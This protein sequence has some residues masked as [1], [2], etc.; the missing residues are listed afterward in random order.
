MNRQNHFLMRCRERVGHELEQS[1]IN[2]II[3]WAKLGMKT[4]SFLNS[5][6]ND[7]FFIRRETGKA[8]RL[9]LVYLNKF[10][11]LIYDRFKHKPI[12]IYSTACIYK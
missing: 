8:D 10:Y 5:P 3:S 2:S 11:Y 7:L 1:V 9:G 4:A 6:I 12:T